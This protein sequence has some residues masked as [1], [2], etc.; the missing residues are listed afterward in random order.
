VTQFRIDVI[1]DPKQAVAGTK[2][3]KQ[4]LSEIDT[5]ANKTQLLL[6]RA[7]RI[8][9]VSFA[10]RQVVDLADS[11]TNLQNRLRVVTNSQAELARV[12]Q[13][14]LEVS[15]RSRS[16]F[17]A[18][19]ELYSR[20]ALSTRELGISSKELLEITESINKAIIL[21]GASAKEAN[22]GLIQLSQGLA[23]GKLSGDE[24]RSTLE[25]L[26]VVADVIAKR[27]GVTRG[28]LR[29]L[30]SEGKITSDIIITAFQQSRE[31]IEQK[32]AKTIPTLSQ[33][34]VV[35]R[36][37]VLAFVGRL[38]EG[39]GVLRVFG[40]TLRFVGENVDLLVKSLAVLGITLATLRIAPAIQGF[41]DL[42]RAVKEGRAVVLGS[43]AAINAQNAALAANAA[44]NVIAAKAEVDRIKQLI[45]ATRQEV[46][47]N[48]AIV[49]RNAAILA[50]AA[51]EQSLIPVRAQL[52]AA[53]QAVTAA[54]ARAAA[55]AAV[56]SSKVTIFSLALGKA[57][58]AVRALG[59]AIAA[60]PAGAIAVA[61]AA[62]I[63]ALVI[64]RNEI[65]LTEDGLGTLGDLFSEFFF[66][67]GVAL[68]FIGDLFVDAFAPA[69]DAVKN[70]VGVIDFE[71]ADLIRVP[72]LFVD[73]TIGLFLGLVN[74]IISIIGDLP[75]AVADIFITMVNAVI[76]AIEFLPDVF[77]G[78]IK[79]I[80]QT[81]SIFIAGQIKAFETLGLALEQSLAGNFS[82]AASLAKQAGE[83][84]ALA[85]RNA[86]EGLGDR[87]VQ[88][89]G[90][91]IDNELIPRL[92]NT[93]ESG[94]A[95]LG[96][97]AL[98]AFVNAADFSGVRDFVNGL[99][100]G[101]NERGA[102]REAAQ[103]A[104]EKAKADTAAAQ[105]EVERAAAIAKVTDAIFRQN[106]VLKIALAEGEREA[107][108]KEKLLEITAK[109]KD[110]QL[111][112]G[113]AAVIEFIVRQN[114]ALQEQLELKERL[115][116]VEEKLAERTRIANEAF[117]AGTISAAEYEQ[118]L[119][120][121]E[122]AAAEAGKSIDDGLTRFYLKAVEASKDLASVTE[123]ILVA[124]FNA[125]EDAL[126]EFATTGQFSFRDFAN[127]L[128]KD[129]IR[130]IAKLLLL[131]AIEAIGGGAGGAAADTGAAVAG[132]GADGAIIPANK[133]FLVGEEGPEIFTPGQTGSITPTD[134]TIEA[135]TNG[136]GRGSETVVVQAPAPAVNVNTIVVDDP[137]KIPAGIE[138]P[139]GQQAVMNVINMNRSNIKR[140]LS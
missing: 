126:V 79:T 18:T 41:F 24:L 37:N 62:V 113:D 63:S 31:E 98:N 137:D 94:F 139:D 2:A 12:T 28:E 133:P 111:N 99:I 70:L 21:S 80:G 52:A 103:A 132:A 81:V 22:N 17:E 20:L 110:V 9:G 36:N 83:E 34:F 134:Q 114:A 44:A 74:A 92:N 1:V 89:I 58:D 33:S 42:S 16:S 11:F 85:F 119:R 64:F 46:V 14:V 5:Q 90:T 4:G 51:T 71:F 120:N 48:N 50:L 84:S 112:P 140:S 35:L 122:L 108:I 93:F 91:E 65:K 135:L 102:E 29:K 32:F 72:A 96:L 101:A 8:A 10:V 59:A 97:N 7:L 109:L 66:Q 138:S 104:E 47:Y 6:Q 95:S 69:I 3:V 56:A 88:N 128:I 78:T 123:D 117:A 76:A 54:E 40:A 60:N 130:I 129:I 55:T 30:G 105:A 86:T 124:S 57:K 15:N 67:L 107:E 100:T 13:A 82:T 19:T 118:E 68:G 115:I 87:F 23:S 127:A 27:L 45:F 26:P 49:G 77:I 131:K 125:A 121:I 39:T 25:Q 116:P 38:N 53:T 136:A 43:V 73:R 106:E 75:P 61:L